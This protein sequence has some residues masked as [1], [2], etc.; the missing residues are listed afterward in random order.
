MK[1]EKSKLGAQQEQ[2]D[3]PVVSDS[4]LE[5]INKLLDTRNEVYFWVDGWIIDSIDYC[6]METIRKETN[7]SVINNYH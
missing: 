7:F 5:Q 6:I 4:C 3:I 2:L 1:T